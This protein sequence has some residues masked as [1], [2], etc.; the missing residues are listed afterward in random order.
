M[1][2]EGDASL[3]LE[4]ALSQTGVTALMVAYER[5][6]ETEREDAL[7]KDPLAKQLAGKSAGEQMSQKMELHAPAFGFADWPQY[8]KQWT[9]CR[10]AFIDNWFKQNVEPGI[11]VVNLGAGVDTRPF[12]LPCLKD[13]SCVF[14]VDREDVNRVK[15]YI[16]DRVVDKRAAFCER[17]V[18]TCDLSNSA[19][20]ER[21]L[22]KAGFDKA[23]PSMWLLEGLLM[24]LN[25]T[26][27]AELLGC[28]SG[29]ACE[30]SKALINFLSVPAEYADKGYCT[31]DYLQMLQGKA[32]ETET[33]TGSGRVTSCPVGWDSVKMYRF[34][35]ADV[36][37]GRFPQ[38]KF[39]PSDSFSLAVCSM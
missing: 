14:E 37:F 36:S 17:K 11:Q 27:Q 15:S 24:Y 28:M 19:A 1:A 34:G 13:V 20:L 18:V 38:S 39:K 35:D 10:T 31:E 12:R 5:A 8:H 21:Q 25:K 33:E 9:V 2:S 23:R 6:L 16:L 26:H 30:G 3:Q 22:S 32:T 7:F 29:L 4:E